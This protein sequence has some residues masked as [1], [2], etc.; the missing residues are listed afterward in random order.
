MVTDAQRAIAEMEEKQRRGSGRRCSERA[1]APAECLDEARNA[2][3]LHA[4][5]GCPDRVARRPTRNMI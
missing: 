1:D 5:S 4:D 2:G 3:R